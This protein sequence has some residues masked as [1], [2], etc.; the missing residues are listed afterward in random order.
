VIEFAKANPGKVTY[1]T[2][3]AGTSLH[4]GMERIAAQAGIKWTQV[5]FKGG[6]ET[7]A[8]VLGKHT[9]LQADST[10][11]KAPVD[12]GQLRHG[13]V[14]HQPPG[15]QRQQA[16]QHHGQVDRELVPALADHADHAV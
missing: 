3:G 11:W 4:I 5:P 14:A 7:N 10:G 2:P 15:A 9:T 16:H 13:R 1:G 8:A 12:G 6:A